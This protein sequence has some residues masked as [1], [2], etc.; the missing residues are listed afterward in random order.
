MPVE[1]GLIRKPNDGSILR[2]HRTDPGGEVLLPENVQ[3]HN[4]YSGVEI[5]LRFMQPEG[6]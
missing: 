1:R 5:A 4:Q 2:E 3:S 6:L